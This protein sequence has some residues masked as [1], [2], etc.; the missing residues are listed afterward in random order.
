MD[1]FVHRGDQKFGPYK[2]ADLQRYVQSGNISIEDMVESEGTAGQVSVS[3][4]LGNVAFAPAVATQSPEVK[5][6]PLPLNLH[7]LLL[8]P[9]AVLTS[10]ISSLIWLVVLANWARKLNGDKKALYFMVGGISVAFI[11]G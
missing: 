4:V 6:V 3:S 9:L 8:L 11:G 5:T 10:Q 7:W 1:Y 2:L